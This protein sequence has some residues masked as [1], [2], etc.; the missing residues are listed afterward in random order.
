M[1][2]TKH[3]PLGETFEIDING[4]VFSA[5][6][7]AAFGLEITGPIGRDSVDYLHGILLAAA[8]RDTFLELIETE[9]LVI[10]KNVRTNANTYRKV[11]GKSSHGRL[12]QAEYF[13]HDGCSCPT[14]PRVVEIRM[15][16]QQ[17]ERH[18]ATAIAP[19]KSVLRAMMVSLPKS[20]RVG[21][22]SDFT[23]GFHANGELP[24]IQQ[25]EK[26]QGRITRLVRR[27]MDAE[28]CRAFFREVDKQA[29][30]YDHP[31]EMGESRLMLNN[32]A[33]LSKT[34]QH[35]RA[36]QKPKGEHEQNGSLM[37]RWTAEEA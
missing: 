4:V 2:F 17:I 11:R 6:K 23:N 10:C 16:H 24:P 32:H 25:W 9:G 20:M 7:P 21:L 31:W 37:K 28:S 34:M 12:S 13:H 27:E 1:T 30:A 35:R 15:P 36:F 14:K 8:H 26:I 18:V 29:S 3:T 22:G 19:F 5:S 33:D